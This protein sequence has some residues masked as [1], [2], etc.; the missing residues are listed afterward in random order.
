RSTRDWSSDVCSSDLERMDTAV[1]VEKVAR[2]RPM[3][4]PGRQHDLARADPVRPVH[5]LSMVGAPPTG[6]RP[7]H[8]SMTYPPVPSGKSARRSEERRVGKEGR[9]G[10]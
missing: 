9:G 1:S 6:C 4:R 2:G 3:T 10:V 7:P 5:A 8:P